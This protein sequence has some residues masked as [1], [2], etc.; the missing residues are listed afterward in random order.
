MNW[1][2]ITGKWMQYKGKAKEKWGELTDNELDMMAGKK[3]Q[4]VGKLQAKYGY[5]KEKAEKEAE[6]WKDTLEP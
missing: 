3:E 4:L 2:Q 5:S 1:E 6:G